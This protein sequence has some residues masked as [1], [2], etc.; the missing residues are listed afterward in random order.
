MM[1][2]YDWESQYN[3]IFITI[4]MEN[5]FFFSSRR[6]HT[7]FS[8]DWSSDVC[9]SDLIYR[10]FLPTSRLPCGFTAAESALS[11]FGSGGG[12]LRCGFGGI[13]G[14]GDKSGPSAVERC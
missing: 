9:S 14:T 6:R 8:R 11:L 7:I 2:N 1:R 4:T 5:Y 10:S 12:F 13:K 3:I